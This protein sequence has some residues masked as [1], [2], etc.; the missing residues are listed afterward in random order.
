MTYK[1][2]YNGL[3][4]LIWKVCFFFSATGVKTENENGKK[5]NSIRAN[6]CFVPFLSL[7]VLI[8]G[9]NKDLAALEE[10]LKSSKALS[11]YLTDSDQDHKTAN[12]KDSD[13]SSESL[14]IIWSKN[15]TKELDNHGMRLCPEQLEASRALMCKNFPQLI[16]YKTQ[17]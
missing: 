8:H 9:R 2:K 7:F 12:V 14:S 11:L 4:R 17:C 5:E 10:I 3:E 6:P 16:F 1:I 13:E 15:K